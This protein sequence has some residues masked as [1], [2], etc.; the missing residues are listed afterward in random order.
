MRARIR[1]KNEKLIQKYMQQVIPKLGAEKRLP[2][3]YKGN[4][5]ETTGW[6][7]G[8][9]AKFQPHWTEWG[10][11]YL[12]L[13]GGTP[14]CGSRASDPEILGGSRLKDTNPSDGLA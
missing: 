11:A 2:K 12:P 8:G 14:P 9:A 3:R 1:L 7:S 6:E 10:E 5:N 4:D 13:K